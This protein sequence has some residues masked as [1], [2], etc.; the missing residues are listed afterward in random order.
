MHIILTTDPVFQPSKVQHLLRH[1]SVL[2]G[3]EI[4]QLTP[5]YSIDCLSLVIV[6]SRL[7]GGTSCEMLEYAAYSLFTRTDTDILCAVVVLQ[8]LQLV[9]ERHVCRMA[10]K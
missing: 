1:L 10:L 5:Y 6:T 8:G 9:P 4:S 3:K 2:I 7:H